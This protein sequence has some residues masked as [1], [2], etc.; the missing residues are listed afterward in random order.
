MSSEEILYDDIAMENVHTLLVNANSKL[1]QA[2]EYYNSDKLSGSSLI[3]ETESFM[4]EFAAAVNG[5]SQAL[6]GID[7]E[8]G[9]LLDA[10]FMSNEDTLNGASETD[11]TNSSIEINLDELTPEKIDAYESELQSSLEG[12][13][14]MIAVFQKDVDE[15]QETLDNILK[16]CDEDD[17]LADF[18]ITLDDFH[19]L[20][21]EEYL[22]HLSDNIEDWECF[23]ENGIFSEEIY[24]KKVEAIKSSSEYLEYESKFNEAFKK[25]TGMTYVEYMEK[26]NAAKEMAS[27]VRSSKYQIKQQLKAIPYLRL[28]ITDEYKEFAS[29]EHDLSNLRDSFGDIFYYENG[30]LKSY[31]DEKELTVLLYLS[32]KSFYER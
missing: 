2:K 25:K 15:M 9:W 32:E 5:A 13:D 27:K 31:L 21:P 19:Y 22:K 23:D 20:T 11:I 14:A 10:L 12:S 16:M 7:T 8:S 26:L 24:K 18:A 3:T 30:E 28:M 6:D 1:I 29:Q 17:I 4:D